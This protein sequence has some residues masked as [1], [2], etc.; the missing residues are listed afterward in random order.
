MESESGKT[1]KNLIWYD[2]ASVIC[3]GLF[4]LVLLLISK[5]GPCWWSVLCV[6]STL[7]ASRDWKKLFHQHCSLDISCASVNDVDQLP[8][9]DWKKEAI[10]WLLLIIANNKLLKRKESKTSYSSKQLEILEN[11]SKNSYNFLSVALNNLIQ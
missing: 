10:H 6:E 7:T 2:F 1:T 8:L 3:M 9:L 5:T 11:C 4:T